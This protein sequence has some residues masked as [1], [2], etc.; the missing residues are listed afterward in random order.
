MATFW[1]LW[2]VPCFFHEHGTVKT[3]D[4]PILKVIWKNPTIIILFHF[5]VILYKKH[6]EQE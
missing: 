1:E 3:D 5:T 2:H 4:V 6:E